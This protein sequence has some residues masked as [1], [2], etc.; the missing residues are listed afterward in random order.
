MHRKVT[1]VV[2]TAVFLLGSVLAFG[3]EKE[4]V[5]GFITSRAGDTVIVKSKDGNATTVILTDDTKTIVA[6]HPAG[7]SLRCHTRTSDPV[8]QG[9]KP[10]IPQANAS[11]QK[12]LLAMSRG[13]FAG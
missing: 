6:H 1:L 5:K 2:A 13:R 10:R 3:Q 4:K 12:H 7:V 11:A 8:V 9:L